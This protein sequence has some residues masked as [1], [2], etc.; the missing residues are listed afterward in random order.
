MRVS[1]LC[2]PKQAAF[3][4]R[5]KRNCH[6]CEQ[7]IQVISVRGRCNC[8]SC[9]QKNLKFLFAVST[10]VIS[11][12]RGGMV[13]KEERFVGRDAELAD[14]KVFLKKKT[15][16]LL[17]IKG[18]RRVG[19]SRLVEQ[20][21]QGL[22]YYEFTGLAP[23]EGV[24]SQVQRDEFSRKLSEQTQLPDVKV[25]DWS[26]L[27]ALLANET[28]TGQVII[29][30]DEVSWMAKGDDTFLS[31]LKNA[32]DSYFKKN[33]K[34]ILILCSSVS[35][36]IEDNILNSTA[37]FGRVSWTLNLDP[38]PLKDCNKMLESQGFKASAYEKFKLLSVTGGIPWYIEQ[39]QGQFNANDNIKRQCFRS[40]GVLNQEFDKIFHDLFDR[41]EHI[42][43]KIVSVLKESTLSYDELSL[44]LNYPKSGRL[45]EYLSDLES[46]GF[47]TNDSTW[48][49]KT[50][51]QSA[52]NRYRLSDNY[53]RF[54]LKFIEPRQ[55]KIKSNRLQ[56]VNLSSL[57]GWNAISGLAFE[58]LVINN[59]K[60][61]YSILNMS[62]E[63]VEF[64]N[65]FFQRKT[66]RQKGC[67]IDYM[68]QTRFKTLYVFEIKFSKEAIKKSIIS[69]VEEKISRMS[70]P[71]G[72]AVL[73]V[74]VHVNGVM[75]SVL[76][77]DYF[78]AMI[79]FSELLK[80]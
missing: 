26:K 38:L 27:F 12:N 64:D 44:K 62:P 21:A 7:K 35:M 17:V 49:L 67:Q 50:R 71:R 63:D 2:R 28:K 33:N 32:W 42:Y 76:D 73:P 43:K 52:L 13:V 74:L 45:S 37:F 66:M 31:K 69:E 20:F 54:Y 78:H 24:T 22:R 75:D 79:D 46:A 16:S 5:R 4:V 40:E 47:I 25:D 11:T 61:I 77:E 29:F 60:E 9:E 53:V 56:D 55:V 80:K 19:K 15:A 34:L 51:K 23:V 65:P 6:S 14:L 1:S 68:I 18:R 36:W 70:L 48:S 10:I 41:R 8:H 72:I 57:P 58:N 3:S 39:M 30:F 59:R